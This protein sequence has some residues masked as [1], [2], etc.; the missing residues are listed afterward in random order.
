MDGDL[1]FFFSL[2]CNCGF[3]LIRCC[4]IACIFQHP[5][6]LRN[7]AGRLKPLMLQWLSRNTRLKADLFKTFCQTSSLEIRSWDVTEKGCEPRKLVYRQ[8]DA[9]ANWRQSYM[10]S[11]CTAFKS[12]L[13]VLAMWEQHQPN[14]VCGTATPPVL[15]M[16][17]I[18]YRGQTTFIQKLPRSSQ[19]RGGKILEKWGHFP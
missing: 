19:E 16:S 18:W 13:L 12:I 11:G 17:C 14:L 5:H 9:V 7:T 2:P 6:L 4:H 3:N 1:V 8:K 15:E 10:F